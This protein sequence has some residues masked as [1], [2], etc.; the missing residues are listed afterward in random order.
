MRQLYINSITQVAAKVKAGE[1]FRE[2]VGKEEG[3]EER[4]EREMK[5]DCDNETDGL[6]KTLVR[7]KIKRLKERIRGV[8][9]A[10]TSPIVRKEKGRKKEEGPG[11]LQGRK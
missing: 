2:K 1:G 7:V 4:K 5:V 8:G 10:G 11:Q 9:G 3:S 6:M